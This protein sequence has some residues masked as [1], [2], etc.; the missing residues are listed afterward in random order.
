MICIDKTGRLV[1]RSV[2]YIPDFT[3]IENNINLVLLN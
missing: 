2:G 1:Y 3:D